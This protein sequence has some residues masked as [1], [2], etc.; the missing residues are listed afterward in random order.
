MMKTFVTRR[1]FF[2]PPIILAA[3]VAFG[4]LTMALWN[5]LLP[6]IFHLPVITFWQA[7]GL[8]ILFRL[9]FGGGHWGH[10]RHHWPRGMRE[11]FERMSP[12]EREKFRQHLHYYGHHW[13]C[14][15]DDEKFQEKK[16]DQ[17]V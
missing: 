9:F 6:G 4:F 15:P 7:I 3:F 2:V 14:C 12:E 16:D 8:L 5:A 11:K 10:G 17:S 1:W 13:R